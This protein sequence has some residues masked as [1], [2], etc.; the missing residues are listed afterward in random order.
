MRKGGGTFAFSITPAEGPKSDLDEENVVIGEV[1]DGLPVLRKLNEIPVSREDAL[2]TK[3]SFA[4]AGA[5][6][7]PRARIIEIE[8]PLKKIKV[9]SCAVDERAS[10]ASFN[11]F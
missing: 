8:R 5:G 7:D 10:I 11:R 6:F 2:G 9:Y 1:L 3:Q 4:K